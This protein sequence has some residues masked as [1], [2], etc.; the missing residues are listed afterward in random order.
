MHLFG[1]G[2]PSVKTSSAAIILISSPPSLSSLE[3][4]VFNYRLSGSRSPRTISVN[5]IVKG[6]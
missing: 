1:K 5:G 2:I 6:S 4:A 3:E